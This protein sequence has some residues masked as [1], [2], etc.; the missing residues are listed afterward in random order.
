M[1]RVRLISLAAA[2][3]VTAIQW[4]AFFSPMLYTQSMQAVG[5]PVTDQAS[6]VKALARVVIVGRM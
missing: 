6:D 4:A 1:K 3:V 2:I 5:S